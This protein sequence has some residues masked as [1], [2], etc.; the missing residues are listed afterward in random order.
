MNDVYLTGTV[1]RKFPIKNLS[2]KNGKETH[3]I[4][5]TMKCP[6]GKSSEYVACEA[7]GGTAKTVDSAGVGAV[8]F[9]RGSI[10]NNAYEGKNGKV[11][12][13]LV[14]LRNVAVLSLTAPSE[15]PKSQPKPEPEPEPVA[16]GSDDDDY[17]NIP[18]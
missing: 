6:N 8:L 5:F 16:V 14:S 17:E 11:Y 18:F 7:W 4:K 3:V 15:A 9:G 12:E 13:Q 1:E 10:R 2:T